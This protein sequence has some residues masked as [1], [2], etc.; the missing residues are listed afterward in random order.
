MTFPDGGVVRWER[1]L[2]DRQSRKS[3]MTGLGDNHGLLVLVLD[4]DSMLDGGVARISLLFAPEEEGP[5]PL[6]SHPVLLRSGQI[7][8]VGGR[9]EDNFHPVSSA[10]ILHVE[11]DNAP[12]HSSVPS[13]VWILLGLALAGA[14]S[15]VYFTHKRTQP[16]VSAPLR[17]DLLSR[18]VSLMEEGQFYLRKDIR[19][20]DVATE[21]G[22]N[23]TYIS[24]CLNGQLGKSFSDFVAEYRVRHA[25]QLLAR[26]PDMSMAQVADESGFS[27]E[28]SF[29]RHFKDLTGQTPSEWRGV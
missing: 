9:M 16:A 22:T 4:Y 18:I 21:L 23:S 27:S 14:A 5:F 25:K 11:G 6:E 29:Y 7:A 15:A 2:V 13:L 17:P 10:F 8:L 26:H 28:R 1:L 19:S 3:Y 20:A 12:V 24:A